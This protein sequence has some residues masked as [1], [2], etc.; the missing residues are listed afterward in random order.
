VRCTW[1]EE[2]CGIGILYS[3]ILG[4]LVSRVFVLVFLGYSGILAERRIE[5]SSREQACTVSVQ[6]AV[7]LRRIPHTG[8][9][10]HVCRAIN[11]SYS[12]VALTRFTRES[13][14]ANAVADVWTIAA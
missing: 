10:H 5:H 7:T 13:V 14:F 2:S 8:V 1:L 12:P 4:I 6:A 3:G 11:E 9:A